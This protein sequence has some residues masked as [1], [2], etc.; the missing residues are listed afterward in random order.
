MSEEY[1]L[2]GY[3][4]N[5]NAIDDAILLMVR[6]GRTLQEIANE[7]GLSISGVNKRLS[8]LEQLGL[9]IKEK[10]KHRMRY[11][12]PVGMAYLETRG[13]TKNHETV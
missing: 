4:R 11:L 1:K 9:L 13:L 2:L 10:R 6:K 3:R 12:T 7:T 8:T 5:L